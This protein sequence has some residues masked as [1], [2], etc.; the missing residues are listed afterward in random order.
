MLEGIKFII[1]S[2]WQL[3]SIT[4]PVSD[5]IKFTFWQYGLFIVII[6][7]LLKQLFRTKEEK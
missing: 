5:T 6:V 7:V 4:V 3:L 1:Q 2:L